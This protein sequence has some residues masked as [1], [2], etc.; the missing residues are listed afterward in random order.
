[1]T[2]DTIREDK[3]SASKS[4]LPSTAQQVFLSRPGSEGLYC[5]AL[6][7]AESLVSINVEL[8][9]VNEISLNVENT[10]MLRAR[11]TMGWLLFKNFR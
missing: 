8:R 2:N 11:V 1:M 4:L 10:T 7:D 9:E 5:A 6:M 3:Q